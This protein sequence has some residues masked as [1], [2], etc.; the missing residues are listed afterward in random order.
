MKNGLKSAGVLRWCGSGIRRHL[1]ATGLLL[2]GL[3]LVA[4][5]VAGSLYTRSII[6]RQAAELQTEVAHRVAGDIEKFMRRKKERLMDLAASLSLDELGS[7][8]QRVRA[9][10]M[11]KNDAGFREVEILDASGKQVMQVSETRVYL[12]GELSDRRRSEQFKQAVAH[13]SYIGP[14]R[15]SERAE[16]YVAVSVPILLTPTQIAGVVSAQLNL[17]FLW[18]TIAES[19][20]GREG[21]AYLVD[22]RGNLIAHRDPSLVLSGANLSHI[23]RVR[24]F[25]RQ[26]NSIDATPAKEAPGILGESVL[27]TFAPV[28]GLGWAVILEEPVAAALTEQ[29]RLLRYAIFVLIT[30][31]GIGALVIMWVSR[32][33][34][35]PI[36]ELHRGAQIIAGGNLDHRVSVRTGDEIEMLAREFNRMTDKL[37]DS[38]A[39]LEQKVQH[40]TRE[41]SALYDVTLSINQSLELDQVLQSVIEKVTDIF[42]FGATRIYLLDAETAELPMRAS[43]ETRPDLWGAV[44]SFSVG[45]GIVGRVAETGEPIIFEDV[46]TDPRYAGLS[47]SKANL[48]ARFSFFAAFPIKI[49]AESVGVITF[50]GQ[51]PR[52]LSPEEVRLLISISNQIG[53][54]VENSTLFHQTISRAREI[55]ALYS[56]AAVLSQSLDINSILRNVVAKVLEI[57]KFDAGRAYFLEHETQELH[58]VAHQGFPEE[59][60]LPKNYNTTQGI[61]GRIFETRKPLFFEDIQKD[62]E[63][64]RIAGKRVLLKAGYRSQFGIPIQAKGQFLGILNFV[65]KQAHRFPATE[66]Q[67]MNSIAYQV[68]VAIENAMLFAEV[69]RKTDRLEQTNRDL[70]ALYSV[71]ATVSRS[72]DLDLMLGGVIRK[73]VE[74]L[75]FDAA[76]IYLVDAPGR[77][78]KLRAFDGISEAFASKTAGDSIGVG[79]NGRVLQ[80][81]KPLIFEDIQSDPAYS[82]LASGKSAKEAGFRSYISIPLMAKTKAVG[83]MNLLGFSPRTFTKQEVELILSMGSQIG[84]AIQNAMLFE[85]LTAKTVELKKLNLELEEA[86]RAKSEFMA[87]MSHELRTPLNVIIGNAELTRSGFFGEVSDRQAD[88]QAKILRYAQMLLAMIN[89]VLT[90]T[91]IDA[92]KMSLEVSTA[93]PAEILSSLQSYIEQLNRDGRLQVEWSVD[94]GCPPLTTDVLKLEEVLQNLVGNAFKFTPQGKIEIRVKHLQQQNRVEFSVADTGIGIDE[95]D[96]AHIFDEFYQLNEAHTGSYAGVGLGLNIVRKYLE[97]MKG[98]IRVQSAVGKGSIFSFTIPYAV[99]RTGEPQT[100]PE[101]SRL[102]G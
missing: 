7:G 44:R 80:D 75:G 53:V 13:G 18:E 16:P 78:L 37:Q 24:D 42:H 94:P 6:R 84:V 99:A 19:R 17:K 86:S 27:S 23:A 48:K 71:A 57:F 102:A 100:S 69:R 3:C 47:H 5:T 30:G 50:I 79:I 89:N 76:R 25:L 1:L 52:D 45:Q 28:K 91:K 49:K 93:G 51:E 70:A 43:F 65:S 81:E 88:A 74:T 101:P 96:L 8:S 15:T 61:M 33:I 90:L 21:Y 98:D 83:V 63:Y 41:L 10:L 56:V 36:L 60:A 14:V 64:Q 9:L 59:L 32:R 31:L 62:D 68:A 58:L 72:L 39:T 22:D 2:S 4:I 29:N 66:V 34:T 55:S 82:G 77:E 12:P 73:A 40:R 46:F 67:L 92:K 26:S 38:Y 95:K 85:E 35:D 11:L 97:L 20:F 54:A 87:A